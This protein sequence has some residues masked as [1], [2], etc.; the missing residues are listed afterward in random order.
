MGMAPW[1]SLRTRRIRTGTWYRL[2]S[3]CALASAC[4]Q[5][6]APSIVDVAKQASDASTGEDGATESGAASK[7]E[8]GDV[9][10]EQDQDP[11]SDCAESAKRVYVFD[12][13]GVVAE[14]D[15]KTGKFR[16]LGT[17]SCVSSNYSMAVDREGYAWLEDDMSTLYRAKL[18][19][20][21]DCQQLD[22]EP[23]HDGF[24][25]FG[26][27]FGRSS[28][29]TGEILYVVAPVPRSQL[30]IGAISPEKLDKRVVGTISESSSMSELSGTGDG[31]LWKLTSMFPSVGDS[32]RGLRLTQIDPR[33]AGVLRSLL[34]DEDVGALTSM[35]VAFW[36][37]SFYAFVGKVG[38]SASS[39][40]KIDRATG[41]VD[42]WIEDASRSIVGAGVSTCAPFELL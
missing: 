19:A 40:Y 39:I 14:F 18:E 32:K 4:G 34:V 41:K 5:D 10:V 28:E 2:V 27:A 25:K 35:A 33:D 38:A 30:Q 3:C 26:M 29:G 16:D 42:L 1:N 9:E 37:G 15:P 7:D 31:E 12:D 36:G 21:T 23:S 17:P 20:L 24:H 13:D 6:L 11:A 22:F 8:E